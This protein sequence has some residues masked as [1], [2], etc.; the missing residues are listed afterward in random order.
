MRLIENG[1]VEATATTRPQSLQRRSNGWSR[2]CARKEDSRWGSRS[3]RG[4]LPVVQPPAHAAPG[5]VAKA[6][7]LCPAPA[8]ILA[9][10]P[11]MGRARYRR[12]HPDRKRL[13]EGH[14]RT[15]HASP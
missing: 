9:C 10:S 3:D 1:C 13:E 14:S 4:V 8:D 5:R 11:A 7:L 6:F 12:R 15:V 2:R